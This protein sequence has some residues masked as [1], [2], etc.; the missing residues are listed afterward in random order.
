MSEIEK[1][2]ILNYFRVLLS[3][4]IKKVEDFDDEDNLINPKDV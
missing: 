4:H 1:D 2:N 3:T